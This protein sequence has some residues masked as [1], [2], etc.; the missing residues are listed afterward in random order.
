M[1][2]IWARLPR[3]ERDTLA[4]LGVL[5]WVL[6]PHALHGPLWAA[7]ASLGLLAWR[8][9]L[10]VGQ[11]PLPARWVRLGVLA[12][13][14]GLSAWQ[15]RSLFGREVGSTLLVLL[16]AL[17]TLELR[18]RRDALV[19]FM[20]GFFLLLSAFMRSQS[21]GLAAWALVGLLALLSLLVQAHRFTQQAR[22]ID[23]VRTALRLAAWGTPLM[24]ALFVFFPRV[25]PLWSLPAPGP[26]GRSGLSADMTVGDVAHLALSDATALRV[27]F[28]G[29]EPAPAALY[30][31][32]P[33]LEITDGRHWRAAPPTGASQRPRPDRPPA[34]PAVQW[35]APAQ[36]YA[37]LDY[38]LTLEPSGLAELLA[39]E[40]SSAP[41]GSELGPL[42]LA[43]SGAWRLAQAPS[44]LIR[45]RA[46]W[47]ARAHLA[48]S[49]QATPEKIRRAQRLN[50]ALPANAHP[51][52]RAWVAAIAHAA[53][54]PADARAWVQ[55]L[56]SELRQGG[57]RYTLDPGLW[58]GD[59]ADTFWFDARA[60]FCEHIASAFVVALRAAGVAARVVTGYQGG[61]RNPL[62][63]AWV[64]RQADAHAWAEVW[65]DDAQ[66]WLRVD[67]T[68]A[69]APARLGE[70]LRL[71]PPPNP[72][73]HALLG[74]YAPAWGARARLWADA[75]QGRWNDWVLGWD[76][77]Q[78]FDLLRH[79]GVN[80]PDWRNLSL[81]LAAALGL[82]LGLWGALAYALSTLRPF[83]RRDHWLR[84]WA[85][86]LAHW[87]HQGLTLGPAPTPRS[88]ARAIQA[89]GRWPPAQCAAWADWLLRL[90]AWRYAPAQVKPVQS[91]N[92]LAVELRALCHTAP[93]ALLRH[94]FVK[95]S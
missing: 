91:L 72:V 67:P 18:A 11:K 87:Q 46:S 1:N 69:V 50:L 3:S 10:A 71:R 75:I 37:A 43:D 53:T 62:D 28:A 36:A 79:L 93:H 81:A 60:G 66:V 63:G 13:F 17:K 56:L 30:F 7:A 26:G 41:Q 82:A 68:G 31:R 15:F 24:A 12:C 22:L 33:V 95:R 54:P 35:L 25:G 92:T 70:R 58:P 42:W 40:G 86:T 73:V 6:A 84:L 4:M 59:P 57:Y 9:A 76:Q 21:L 78:Q 52:T 2:D 44:A 32:G 65:L 51:R 83:N 90:E 85:R 47:Q 94:W 20:L 48:P 8:A 74:D 23:S 89:H 14:V 80:Q 61:E 16:L 29:A 34:Q 77:R 55:R 45:Y 64:V 39:P 49:A 5:L 38:E 19:V 27:R 88:L